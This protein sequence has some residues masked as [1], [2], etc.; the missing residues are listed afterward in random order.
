MPVSAANN[1]GK[2][3]AARFGGEEFVMLL[4]GCPGPA[5]VAFAGRLRQRIADTLI[6]TPTG[7][8]GVTVSIGVAWGEDAASELNEAID[9]ADR[10]LYRAKMNGR[11]RVEARLT[12]PAA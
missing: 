3:T 8:I 11:N 7:A 12:N 5:A 10:A 9:R 1:A 4:P 6:E 2:A